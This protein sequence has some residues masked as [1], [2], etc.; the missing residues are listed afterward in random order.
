[1]GELT[2]DIP[3]F[4]NLQSPNL[5]VPVSEGLY[6]K[7]LQIVDLLY[8]LLMQLTFSVH[9]LTH[10]YVEVWRLEVIEQ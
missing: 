4:N 7:S 3:L 8:E 10:W 9:I 5:Y 6:R 2:A 1:M